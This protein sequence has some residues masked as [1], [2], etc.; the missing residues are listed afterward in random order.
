MSRILAAA[1]LVLALC[2]PVFSQQALSPQQQSEN[3]QIAA[4]ETEV[5]VRL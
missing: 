5:R 1:C 4:W 3:N 2:L